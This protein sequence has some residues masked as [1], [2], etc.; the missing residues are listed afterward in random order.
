M[1]VMIMGS[2]VS[3]VPTTTTTICKPFVLDVM[4]FAPEAGFKFQVSVEKDCT[5]K[6]EPLWKLV[7]DL[8]KKQATGTDFDQIVHVS[9]T[10]STP[11]EAQVIQST[12]ANGV[13]P[14][15]ADILINQVHPA[16][17]EL[18]DADNMTPDQLAAAKTE[19]KAGMSK[20][21]NV[22]SFDL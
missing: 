16:V 15:Q 18:D 19:V 9:Y 6:A 7:F 22:K 11:V 1:E 10:A 5:A 20:V 14:S 13:S 21:A 3:I 8:Y 17:K 12:A 2:N 4:V